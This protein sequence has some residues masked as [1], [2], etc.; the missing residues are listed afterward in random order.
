MWIE[1]SQPCSFAVLNASGLN[2]SKHCQN[3]SVL[4]V[5]TIL[6]NVLLS[7]YLMEKTN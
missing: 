4:M 1:A 7:F 2:G 6:R 5:K 3:I